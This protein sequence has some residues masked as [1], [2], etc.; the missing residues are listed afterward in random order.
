MEWAWDLAW[1][2]D[3]QPKGNI[4][5][6]QQTTVRHSFADDNN[7][8]PASYGLPTGGAFVVDAVCTAGTVTLTLKT[9]NG[10]PGSWVSARDSSGE[11]ITKDM[12]TTEAHWHVELL[13]H[14]SQEFYVD[15]TSSSSVACDV[16]YG[17]VG[18]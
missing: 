16:T 2:S 8:D 10:A 3:S 5:A 18:N 12:S 7:T 14:G 6:D 13:A 9:R 1:A 17:R 11:I 4:V 15:P